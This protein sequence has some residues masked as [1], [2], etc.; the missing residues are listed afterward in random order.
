VEVHPTRYTETR[1]RSFG[2]EADSGGRGL[3]Q[4]DMSGPLVKRAVRRRQVELIEA[5]DDEGNDLRP[6]TQGRR[7]EGEYVDIRQVGAAT[8]PVQINLEPPGRR[9]ERIAR[10]RGSLDLV[11]GGEATEVVLEAPTASGGKVVENERLGEAGIRLK[12][13][14]VPAPAEDG[15]RRNMLG[16]RVLAGEALLMAV[17][18]I[19][20][21]GAPLRTI[22]NRRADAGEGESHEAPLNLVTIPGKVPADLRLRLRF[23]R[24]AKIVRI[25]FEIAEVALP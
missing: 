17:E 6:A 16:Y 10:I 22:V 18:L 24:G 15:V 8:L 20:A 25:P 7:W 5:T 3:L 1:F 12:L 23:L 19:D 21:E 9:A 4:V 11:V 14:M 13:E 2:P